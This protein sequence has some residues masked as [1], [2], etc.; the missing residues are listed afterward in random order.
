MGSNVVPLPGTEQDADALEL[1]RPPAITARVNRVEKWRAGTQ[2]GD[3][4]ATDLALI[5][6][7]ADRGD[8]SRYAEL[9]EWAIKSD[10]H[11][12]SLY[13]TRIMR[14]A[15]A[16]YE[17]VPSEFGDPTIAKQAADFVREQLGR[18]E[19]FE[20]ARRDLLHA[21]ALGYSPAEMLWER[22]SA[23]QVY[24]VRRIE[25][26]HP[27]RFKYGDGWQLRWNERGSR[28]G[29]DGSGELLRE[30]LWIVHEHKE[31]ASYPGASG[32]MRACLWAWMFGRWVEK[33]WIGHVEKH[34]SPIVY[35]KV[36]PKTPAAV[37]EAILAGLQNLSADHTAVLEEGTEVVV[38]SSASGSSTTQHE[39]F[40]KF[41]RDALTK[42]WL[43]IS[44]AVDPGAN[45]SNAAVATRAGAA[46]DPRMVADGRNLCCTLEQTLIAYLLRYNVHKFPQVGEDFTRIPIPRM[47]M[48]TAHDEV[49]PDAG[50]VMREQ[51]AGAPSSSAPKAEAVDVAAIMRESL[52]SAAED[53]KQLS[54]AMVML[55][56][57]VIAMQQGHATDPKAVAAARPRQTGRK[58]KTSQTG[59]DC[60]N[61]L[62]MALLGESAE[63]DAT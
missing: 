15:Q 7:Q 56:Q 42:A 61:P 37:R 26:R 23:Q 62:A 21:I 45:G 35:A 52:A 10:A 27:A 32:V 6:Q 3:L 17:V 12:A 51:P 63:S 57:S 50:E 18:I 22:D 14:V 13:T 1:R 60:P 19:N 24:Y 54:Q 33:F 53:R 46:M 43:G 58:R 2:F 34:G 9:V 41:N 4:G 39:T 25:W 16:E 28:P 47:R 31:I 29:I 48:K 49:K 55:S 5:V 8:V 44:D 11:L 30:G 38:D 40:M 20:H 59:A 36:K